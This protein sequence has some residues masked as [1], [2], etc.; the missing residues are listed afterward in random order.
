MRK[1]SLKQ[2]QKEANSEYQLVFKAAMKKFGIKSPNELKDD[3]KKKFFD[4]VD[5][6][7]TTKKESVSEVSY[8]KKSNINLDRKSVV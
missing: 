4:Y 5:S 2:L 1:T 3:K 7:W 6:Q 8:R